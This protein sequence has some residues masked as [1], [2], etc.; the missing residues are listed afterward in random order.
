MTPILSHPR[1]AKGGLRK[2][3]SNRLSNPSCF[4]IPTVYY[5]ADKKNLLLQIFYNNL[6]SKASVVLG[7]AAKRKEGME[8]DRRIEHEKFPH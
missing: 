2:G 3:E 5:D 8:C 6:K 1:N 4:L 7:K